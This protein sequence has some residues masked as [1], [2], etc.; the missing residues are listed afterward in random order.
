LGIATL[1]LKELAVAEE[2]LTQSNI[3]E[4]FNGETHGYMSLLCLSMPH[5]S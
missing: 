2:C 3:Y 1:R 4:P 5:R